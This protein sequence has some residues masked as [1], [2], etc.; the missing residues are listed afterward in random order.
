VTAD[1]LRPAPAPRATPRPATLR[2][3]G[4]ADAPALARILGDWVRE[5]GWMPVLHS[6]E[7]DEGFLRH[8]IATTEVTVA[9]AGAPLGF[10]SLDGEEVRAL[11]LA[12]AGRGQGWGRRLLDGAKARSPRLRLWTFEANMGARAFYAREGFQVVRG[13]P[14]DNDERL[15][16]LLLAWEAPRGGSKGASPDALLD[17]SS[18]APRGTSWDAARD[19]P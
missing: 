14:G 12:P 1:A 16:D 2:P 15:P 5:A 8:L 9:E 3:A 18:D 13:T 4:A 10:L 7:E 19:A 17:A 11:Y 6:R